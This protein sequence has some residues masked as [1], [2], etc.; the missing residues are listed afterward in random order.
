MDGTVRSPAL[1]VLNLACCALFSLFLSSLGHASH[2]HPAIL[3]NSKVIQDHGFNESLLLGMETFKNKRN[4]DYRAESQPDIEE[5]GKMLETLALEKYDPIVVPGFQVAQKVMQIAQRYPNTTFIAIDY[6]VAASNVYSVLFKEQEGAFLAGYLAS[7]VSPSHRFGFVG[8]MEVPV[9]Q[10]FRNGFEA[11]LKFANPSAELLTSYL[12]NVKEEGQSSQ[13]SPW[14]NEEGA[15]KAATQLIEEGVDIIFSAA[16]GANVGVINTAADAGKLVIGVDRDQQSLRPGKVLT[17]VEKRLDQA[18]YVALL[19]H[20]KG[21]WVSQDKYLGVAQGAI[22]VTM[23]ESNAELIPPEVRERFAALK[24]KLLTGELMISESGNL[25]RFDFSESQKHMP[26]MLVLGMTDQFQFPFTTTD[27]ETINGI[28]P[29]LIAEA[30][31][32]LNRDLGVTIK[33]VRKPYRKLIVDLENNAI[34]GVAMMTFDFHHNSIARF[35]MDGENVDVSKRMFTERW[36]L[37]HRKEQSVPWQGVISEALGPIAVREEAS[38]LP[39]L[40]KS[41]PLITECPTLMGCFLALQN[42]ERDY[43]V[44]APDL[45]ARKVLKELFAEGSK[46]KGDPN[47]VMLQPYINDKH[48]YLA[49][50]NQFYDQYPLFAQHAWSQLSQLRESP[51]LWEA[52]DKYFEAGSEDTVIND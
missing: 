37:F 28:K 38:I 45:H 30:M 24:K 34:N 49:F 26:K 31:E 7:A 35:P 52:S 27:G 11:G 46:A 44:A 21:R 33:L 5:Y 3:F 4:V 29:G 16:G 10:R 23:N 18:V 51:E 1:S 40:K 41:S 13:V 36:A 39:E 25:T 8:G 48:Y 12:D 17:S 19:N 20:Q 6:S 15:A 32:A 42:K 22:D 9:I 2:F 50:S 43:L 14:E 47:I